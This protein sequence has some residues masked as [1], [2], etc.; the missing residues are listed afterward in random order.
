MSHLSG[1]EHIQNQGQ[2]L[3]LSSQMFN[4]SEVHLGSLIAIIPSGHAVSVLTI[5]ASYRLFYSNLMLKV[6]DLTFG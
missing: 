6:F 5:I 3:D 1:V 4:Q 2:I